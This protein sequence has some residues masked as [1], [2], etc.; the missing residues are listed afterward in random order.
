MIVSRD[1][2]W[3]SQQDVPDIQVRGATLYRAKDYLDQRTIK[4]IPVFLCGGGMRMTYYRKLGEELKHFQ[5]VSWLKATARPLAIPNNLQA[6][7]LI[8]EDYDRL[9]VA[10]GLS[11]LEV[12]LIVRELPKPI[13]TGTQKQRDDDDRFISKDHM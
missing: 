5:G 3:R 10:F 8:R 13:A 12:G 11:F 6:P 9:S 2:Q 7:G 1:A 4:G